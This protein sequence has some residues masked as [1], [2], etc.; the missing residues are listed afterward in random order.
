MRCS[1]TQRLVV[2]LAVRIDLD[3]LLEEL[4]NL[5]HMLL[6]LWVLLV[7][8]HHRQRWPCR[9]SESASWQRFH[10]RVRQ[11]VRTLALGWLLGNLEQLATTT[12]FSF[13]NGGV[14]VL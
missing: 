6:Y 11:V 5:G 1:D 14:G 3:Q 2:V 10:Q 4:C 12:E 9:E 13:N 8:E 7:Q